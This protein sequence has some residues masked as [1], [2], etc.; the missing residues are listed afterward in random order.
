MEE[1]PSPMDLPVGCTLSRAALFGTLFARILPTVSSD[2]V[3]TSCS[4]C[5]IRKNAIKKGSKGA[6]DKA[7]LRREIHRL[8]LGQVPTVP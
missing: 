2:Y 4:L 8:L 3:M 7:R 6:F 1:V 5:C